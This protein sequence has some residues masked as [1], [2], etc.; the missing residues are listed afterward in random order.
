MLLYTSY[1]V[2]YLESDDE[3]WLKRKLQNKRNYIVYQFSHCELFCMIQANSMVQTGHIHIYHIQESQRSCMCVLRVPILHLFTILIFDFGVFRLHGILECSDCMVFW[4]VP[5]AWYF[6]V[7]RLH[8]TLECSDCM[9]FQSDSTA[10]YFGV[11][12]LHGIWECSDCM[13]FWSVP[14][15]WYFGVFRLHG[16]WECSDCMVF[17]C[18]SFY[19]YIFLT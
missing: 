18:L 19:Q 4:S 15:A 12:R 1:L 10:W 8:G 14:T 6:R 16:I 2:L 3:D 17:C 5:I 7:I 13:V 9:V 11:F